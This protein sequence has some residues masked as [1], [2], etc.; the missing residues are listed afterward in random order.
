MPP[1]TLLLAGAVVSTILSGAVWLMMALSDRD[2]HRI[3]GW[4]MGGLSTSGWPVVWATGPL[5][6][7]GLLLLTFLGRPLD[8][9]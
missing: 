6:A 8:A 9:V 7:A 5:I 4:L 3:V 1:V 2:L